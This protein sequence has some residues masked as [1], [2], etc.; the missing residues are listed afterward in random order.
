MTEKRAA[1]IPMPTPTICFINQ[2]GGCGKSSG[3]FHLA[4][5]FAKAGANVLLVDADPQGSLSQGF[6]GSALVESLAARDS[7]AAI[8]GDDEIATLD[9]LVVPTAFDGLSLIRAN[10]HLAR[11]N[12]PEPERS[13]MRQFSLA[14]F[15]GAATGFDLILI[16]CPPNLYQCSWNA[17]LASNFV[18][19]PVPPEDFATQGLR[20]IHQ[21]VEQARL[22]NPAL[23]LIGHL[24]IRA[25]SRL[26]VHRAYEQQLRR[27]YGTA[28]LSTVI[29]EASAY[30]V[31]LS[32]RKPVSFYSQ[33]SK[34]ARLMGTLGD[35]ILQRISQAG[36]KRRI[37]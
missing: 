28:V 26:L 16:D 35:E 12:V 7:L 31:S 27:L 23:E 13:G 11:H 4:G 34:A 37:A 36:E 15:L 24:I 8:F 17:L 19:V 10:F 18:V 25:D 3:C 22:L 20:I 9:S 21:A 33:A 6:F 29:P 2:K 30:K 14:S 5:H 32:C 1:N